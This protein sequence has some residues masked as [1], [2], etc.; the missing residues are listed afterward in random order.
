MRILRSVVLRMNRFSAVLCGM[1]VL[2]LG[3]NSIVCGQ[4]TGRGRAESVDSWESAD[5]IQTRLAISDWAALDDSA[6]IELLTR[7]LHGER[8]LAMLEVWRRRGA[9]RDSVKRLALDKDPEVRGRANWILGQWSRGVVPETPKDLRQW[10]LQRTTAESLQGLLQQGYFR[11]VVVA[12]EESASRP[13]AQAVRDRVAANLTNQFSTY[14]LKAYESDSILDLIEI[15]NLVSNTVELAVSRYQLSREL[16][17]LDDS[18]QLL[19]STAATWTPLLRLQAECVLRFLHGD[20]AGAHE[21]ASQS[22]DP[23]LLLRLRMVSGE[24]ESLSED[25]ALRAKDSRRGSLERT[26]LLVLT[27]AASDRALVSPLL[28]ARMK[29]LRD[30]AVRQLLDE[31]IE[32]SVEGKLASVMRWKGLASHGEVNQAV[33]LLRKINPSDAAA[34]CKDSSRV[35]DAFDAMERPLSRVDIELDQWI[36]EALKQQRASNVRD[37]T[38]EIREMLTLMQCLIAIGYD[39]RGFELAD[40]LANSGV[41]LGT[42]D[43]REF[44]LSTLSLTKKMDWILQLAVPPDAIEITLETYNTISRNLTDCELSTLRTVV[45]AFAEANPD[46]T[47]GENLAQAVE[48]FMAS[49]SELVGDRVHE[50]QFLKIFTYL[51]KDPT[52]EQNVE[53]LARNKKSPRLNLDFVKLFRKH[54]QTRFA[55]L[56]LS[57]LMSRGDREAI[58]MWAQWSA[59]AGRVE[60]AEDAYLELSRTS[61]SE[62]G[63]SSQLQVKSDLLPVQARIGLWR[64]A[65]LRQDDQTAS[66]LLQGIRFALCSPN[67]SARNE[68][69]EY[70][71]D[72]AE[73]ELALAV[74]ENLLPVVAL[75]QRGSLGLYD[76]ARR[77]APLIQKSQPQS[78]AKWFDLALNQTLFD[79]DFRAGAYVTLPMF[80]HRWALEAE[81]RDENRDRIQLRLSRMLQLDAMDIDF[82][83]RLLPMMREIGMETDAKNVLDEIIDQGIAHAARFPFDAMT[84][85]NVAWVAAVNRQRL[86]DALVLSKV[87]VRAEPESPVY[88][89]TL[90]EVLFQLE[91]PEEALQIEEACLLDDP[92]QWHLHE[93]C[94]KYRAG[95]NAE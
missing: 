8:Q 52:P 76:V 40:Q 30:D 18:F 58:L 78:A 53:V 72:T 79:V 75:G 17:S 74:F 24:W 45:G 55:E 26:R 91:R 41:K 32:D 43:L 73:S 4:A 9:L 61:E 29:E 20:L 65:K 12:L 85:N 19:P 93:Q 31:P 35:A 3:S 82:A 47:L 15:L 51:F 28:P 88:R 84:A 22:I 1:V 64:L 56:C 67:L 80:V 90:A 86:E 37:L 81:I 54:G 11:A 44:V 34:L 38:P 46:A 14:A 16:G 5:R 89:D 49:D 39:E 7:D 69:G 92:T 13:D 83:E 94:S 48:L 6:L 2:C 62:S 21:K 66:Q 71:A 70:L 87:S 57:E 10:L 68:L 60:E 77:Y 95:L 27:L 25:L 23:E 42:I 50:T 36:A 33:E 59:D 63:Q